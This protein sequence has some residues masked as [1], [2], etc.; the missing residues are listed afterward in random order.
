MS[1]TRVIVMPDGKICEYV[2]GRSRNDT[3]EEYVRQTIEK[4]LVSLDRSAK[5]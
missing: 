2:D 5:Q 4:R 1:E 3:P